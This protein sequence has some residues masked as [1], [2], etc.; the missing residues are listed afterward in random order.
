MHKIIHNLEKILS[1][2]IIYLIFQYYIPTE[3]NKISN[4][5]HLRL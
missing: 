4:N 1:D 2:L 3:L 5:N